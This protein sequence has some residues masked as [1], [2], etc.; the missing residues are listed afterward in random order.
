M[1]LQQVTQLDVSELEPPQPMH[2]ITAALQ[3]LSTGDVL[4]IKHRRIPVPLFEMIAGRFDYHYNEI[5]SCH[6]QLYFWQYGDN[7][8]KIRAEKL[9]LES[10]PLEKQTSNT[11]N[12][13]QN[14]S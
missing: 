13:E 1:D 4:A 5:T 8:A 11:L 12:R 7:G 9:S 3:Q 6:F 14:K 2:M 10:L